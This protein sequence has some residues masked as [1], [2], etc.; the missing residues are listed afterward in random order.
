[1]QHIS[2]LCLGDCQTWLK[3]RFFTQNWPNCARFESFQKLHSLSSSDP[4]PAVHSL[5]ATQT[6]PHAALRF[7][8]RYLYFLAAAR[9]AHFGDI[10]AS[11]DLENEE[12]MS[13]NRV[14]GSKIGF[15]AVF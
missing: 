12:I 5:V 7:G 4:A 11:L 1:M 3:T 14:M 13:S 8:A 10:I 2:D 15:Y 9:H 6:H